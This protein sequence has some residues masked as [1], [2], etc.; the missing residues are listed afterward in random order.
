[1][2][3]IGFH[4]AISLLLGN[5][6]E[7]VEPSPHGK[8]IASVS[9]VFQVPSVIRLQRYVHVPQRHATWSRRGVLARDHYIC[10]YCGARLSQREA[11]VDHVIS[12]RLCRETGQPAN[13]WTNTVASCH[14]CQKRKGGRSIHAA[15]MRF[16]DTR[17]EPK[18]PR[19]SYL[20]FTSEILPEW[21]P[22][23]QV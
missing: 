23:I 4:R 17:F 15:G 9:R 3:V 8:T 11:T 10:Q 1:L 18:T 22:Y 13:T 21:K 2:H 5:K 6:V 14:A 19:V 16:H 12:Q 7:M 20:V